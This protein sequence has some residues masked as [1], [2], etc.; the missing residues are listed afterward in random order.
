MNLREPTC[1]P[2]YAFI[3]LSHTFWTK[4]GNKYLLRLSHFILFCFMQLFCEDLSLAG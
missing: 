2:W 4:Q 3:S 1:F